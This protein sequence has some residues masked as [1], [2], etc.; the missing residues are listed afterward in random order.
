MQWVDQAVKAVDRAAQAA[1]EQ[2]QSELT[3]PAGALG[4]LERVAI[5]LAGLQGREAPQAENIAITIFAAD[6]GVA[7]EGVSAFPQAVTAQMIAN[8]AAGGAAV[9]VLANQL[10][11]PLQ[12]VNLGTVEPV[13]SSATVVDAVIAPQTANLVTEAAMT[14][15]QLEQAL[16]AG[17][18]QVDRHEALD[19]FIGGEM[20][21]A[22]TTA[23]SALAAAMLVQPVGDLTGPGAGLDASGVTRKT[24]VIAKALRVHR[25]ALREPMETLRCLGGFEIAALVGAYLRCA[26]RG[27]PVLVD[28]FICSV[29][30]L[31]AKRLNPAVEPWLILS[32]RSAEP[33]SV[34]IEQEFSAAPLLDLGMRLGEGSGAALAVPLI[35]S[36][37]A[38]HNGMATFA[39][40]EV[41]GKVEDSCEA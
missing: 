31:M 5:R 17:R 41:S 22:N 7:E 32:H 3:K 9:S 33:A 21:I 8:F 12:V 34:H 38:L 24:Q 26:Q 4:E 2:R 29:A 14:E 1:A 25:S 10:G 6:H 23:A 28:G 39:E 30:A 11:L 40:A 37:C 27:I 19:L 15:E 20:G 16:A 18:D 13:A 36:A 35:R